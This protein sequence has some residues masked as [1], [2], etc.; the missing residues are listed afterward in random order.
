MHWPTPAPPL[1]EAVAQSGIKYPNGHPFTHIT[2]AMVVWNDAVRAAKLLAHVRPWFETLV[3]GVQE[4]PDDTLEAV[5]AIADVV[6]EDAH[7]GYGDA[8]FGPKLLPRVRTPWTL[9]IDADEW[10]SR[11]LLSSLSNATWMADHGYHTS[12]VWVPFKSSVDGIEYEEQHAHL[13]LFHT[14]AGWP[15]LLH[16]TPPINDGILW[17]RGHIR[18]DRS[19]DEMIRDY[20]GY[21]R[22]GRGNAG[23]DAH[24]E[25]MIRSACTGTAAKKGWDY[26]RSFEWWPQVAAIVEKET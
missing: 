18:H 4:S 17:S 26:V 11:D 13:R 24:N 8:T 10:P 15:A 6:V 3:V 14:S 12:G 23:W 20:L 19:L 5:R 9:K 21:L 7:Q 22:I 2:F 25:L 1:S 16:S